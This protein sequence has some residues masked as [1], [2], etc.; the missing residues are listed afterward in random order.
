MKLMASM[1]RK[2]PAARG[3]NHPTFERLVLST[4]ELMK[5]FLVEEISTDMVLQHSG[6]SRGSLYHHF[7][8]LADLL[9]T[10][11]VRIFAETVDR[12][13][14]LI[15]GLIEKAADATEF[16]RA[17]EQFNHVTQDPAR[18]D[19]RFERFR[20][21]GFACKNPRMAEKLAIEQARL[22]EIYAD[23]FREAQA[24]GLMSNDFDPRAAAVLIQ[25]YTLGRAVDDLVAD[26]VDPDAWNSLIMKIVTRVFGASAN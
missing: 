25:A 15:R 5:E 26:P 8:D 23:L 4:I 18:R 17:T 13:I 7:E 9:E 3:K 19:V 14:E 21:I 10:A 11:M 12:N 2:E 1:L 20:L 22:T 16:Y 24:K 6:V